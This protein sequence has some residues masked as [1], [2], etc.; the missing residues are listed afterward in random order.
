MTFFINGGNPGGGNAYPGVNVTT[1][2][3]A[4]TLIRDSMLNATSGKGW[5]IGDVNDISGTSQFSVDGT[6][7]NNN[8]IR[9]L[10]TGVANTKPGMASHAIYVQIRDLDASGT[11]ISSEVPYSPAST[12]AVP[13]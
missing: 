12:F 6:D 9:M 1:L 5:I 7:T 11:T 10:F 2:V 3:D 8:K 4:L 13:P